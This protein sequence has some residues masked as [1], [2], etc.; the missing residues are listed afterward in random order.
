MIDMV[1]E[2][3]LEVSFDT[4]I[5]PD[6][7]YFTKEDKPVKKFLSEINYPFFLGYFLR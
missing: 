7:S 2:S 6:Y 3:L 1:E 4:E 5:V